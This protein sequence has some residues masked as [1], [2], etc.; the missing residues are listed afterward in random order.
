MVAAYA[1]A[2]ATGEVKREQNARDLSSRDYAE[3]LFS[4]GVRKRWILER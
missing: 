4:D 3:S 1:E 2:E